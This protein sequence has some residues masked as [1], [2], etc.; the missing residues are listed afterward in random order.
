MSRLSPVSSTG[1][2]VA[3][4]SDA[5]TFQN[6]NRTRQLTR[7][8]SGFLAS[9]AKNITTNENNTLNRLTTVTKA[10]QVAGNAAITLAKT[11]ELLNRAAEASPA[12]RSVA[13]VVGGAAAGALALNPVV[14][15]AVVACA[16]IIG[17]ALKQKAAHANLLT[18]MQSH[19]EKMVHLVRFTNFA[20]YIFRM[21]V[22][23]NPELADHN[24]EQLSVK[25]AAEELR[26]TL[27]MLA[28]DKLLKQLQEDNIVT[29]RNIE[30]INSTRMISITSSLG[31]LYKT[32]ERVLTAE[33]LTKKLEEKLQRLFNASSVMRTQFLLFLSMHRTTYEQI[34]G[35]VIGTDYYNSLFSIKSNS[36][37]P[38]LA[39]DAS[40]DDAAKYLYKYCKLGLNGKELEVVAGPLTTEH[41]LQVINE[42][43]RAVKDGVFRQGEIITNAANQYA[44]STDT[45]V[46]DA[47]KNIAALLKELHGIDVDFHLEEEIDEDVESLRNA[48]SVGDVLSNIP[49]LPKNAA[50]SS[51]PMQYVEWYPSTNVGRPTNAVPPPTS[52]PFQYVEWSPS[53][54]VGRPTNA[55]PPLSRVKTSEGAPSTNVGKSKPLR[56]Q[57]AVRSLQ[58]IPQIPQVGARRKLRKTRKS[59]RKHHRKTARQQ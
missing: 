3:V 16:A 5:F 32:M 11:S 24:F 37:I 42:A 54:N 10:V 34:L 29:G 14:L 1:S 8:Q 46:A 18:V 21:M 20:E 6:P 19:L 39:D 41:D 26:L 22:F 15:P 30:L 33:S 52:S 35:G 58:P 59:K 7:Q 4:N 45:S 56:R 40:N 57:E 49:V 53:T 31:R 13:I 12:L 47:K 36:S 25:N 51:S 28:N 27:L 55:V 48:S 44:A 23:V 2:A 38:T 9:V 50:P 43:E 17:F